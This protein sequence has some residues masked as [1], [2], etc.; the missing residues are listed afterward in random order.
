MRVFLISLALVLGLSST[1]MAWTHYMANFT[2]AN[3][4]NES[5]TYSFSTKMYIAGF[6]AGIN[7]ST[8]RT[9][10]ENGVEG[11]YLWVKNY[12]K[13]NPLD[14]INDAVM[15]LDKELDRRAKK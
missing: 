11:F 9:T 6:V 2:C 4:V 15:A 10:D 8:N 5:E 13:E 3:V 14:Y 12:C 7:Y 1:S